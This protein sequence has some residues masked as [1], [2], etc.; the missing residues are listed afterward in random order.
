MRDEIREYHTTGAQCSLTKTE[1]GDGEAKWDGDNHGGYW[2]PET[3]FITSDKCGKTREPDCA[4]WSR[5][6]EA[7]SKP[8]PIRIWYEFTSKHVPERFSFIPVGLEHT[9]TKWQFVGSNDE[10]CNHD[11]T[12]KPLCGDMAP[13]DKFIVEGEEVGCDVPKCE[14]QPFKCL[15]IK[16]YS[17]N[18]T[19]H[20][21]V[22][23]KAMRFW[24]NTHSVEG[25][26]QPPG[27]GPYPV[28]RETAFS[29]SRGV[30]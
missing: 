16:V 6:D 23:I 4:G 20:N 12:W 19:K 29:K 14:K 30:R 9:P 15:G 5:S 26:T 28:R 13:G 25:G 1:N 3:A 8:F 7:Y 17:T 21:G 18:S 10:G 27:P 22:C 24:D 2:G 11:S